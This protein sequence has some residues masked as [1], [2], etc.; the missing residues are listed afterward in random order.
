MKHI[1]TAALLSTL[2]V[3]ALADVRL[4]DFKQWPK[5]F[6][7]EGKDFWEFAHK[8]GD[9]VL[10]VQISI[11]GKNNRK[12]KLKVGDVSANLLSEAGSA[13]IKSRGC[14]VTDKQTVKNDFSVALSYTC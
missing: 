8:K 6:T 13:L 4:L 14:K 12:N 9:D 11:T 2:A 5:T 10:L 7:Y 1:I 3:P